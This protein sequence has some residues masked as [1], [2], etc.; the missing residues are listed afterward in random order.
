MSREAEDGDDLGLVHR[1]RCRAPDQ[2]WRRSGAGL[3][4]ALA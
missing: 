3:E 1:D 4:S 2:A